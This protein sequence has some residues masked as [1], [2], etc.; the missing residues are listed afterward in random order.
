MSD[1]E[2][3][4]A[5]YPRSMR[6]VGDPSRRGRFVGDPPNLDRRDVD[7]FI[8]ATGAQIEENDTQKRFYYREVKDVIVTPGFKLFPGRTQAEY[9]SGLFHEL[10]HWVGHPTRLDRPLGFDEES[11]AKE[12]LVAE[13]G[14]ALLCAEFSIDDRISY[15]HADY[16]YHFFE[17][18][19]EDPRAVF[20]AV[21]EAKAAVDFLHQLFDEKH[22]VTEKG[23][24]D[25][26]ST[27]GLR[28]NQ[29]TRAAKKTQLAELRYP[30]VGEEAEE[31]L[32]QLYPER[33]VI[34]LRRGLR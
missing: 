31:L 23:I 3:L 16:V 19:D 8:A 7:E 15:P 11:E 12:E 32:D 1:I 30:I 27:S 21:L 9:Y 5:P 34:A 10:V 4:Y 33:D 25:D 17:L 20:T 13:L 28:R 26:Y 2:R 6:F 24:L 18:L 22:G 14:A 29:L